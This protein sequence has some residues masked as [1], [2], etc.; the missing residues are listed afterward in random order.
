MFADFD[1][2]VLWMLTTAKTNTGVGFSA[3]IANYILKINEIKKKEN[4]KIENKSNKKIKI[5]HQIENK[6]IKT[7]KRI[8]SF[9]ATSWAWPMLF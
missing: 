8:P 6:K 9:W 4:M 1:I 7:N 5:K 3:E 2:R